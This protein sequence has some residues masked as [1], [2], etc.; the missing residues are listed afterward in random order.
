LRVI[1]AQHNADRRTAPDARP[2]LILRFHGISAEHA[3]AVLDGA[4]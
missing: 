4:H 1:I 2:P 3:A